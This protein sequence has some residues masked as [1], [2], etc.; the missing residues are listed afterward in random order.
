MVGGA[1][2]PALGCP[3]AGELP[4]VG[5]WEQREGQGQI[6]GVSDPSGIIWGMSWGEETAGGW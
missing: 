1:G 4:L 3:G 2:C 5:V 6:W